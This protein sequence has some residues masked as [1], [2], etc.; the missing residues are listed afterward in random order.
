MN[1]WL[2]T[3]NPNPGIIKASDTKAKTVFL[4]DR[5]SPL[6]ITAIAVITTPMTT[7]L[8]TGSVINQLHLGILEL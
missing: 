6:N 2:Q 7:L 4:E 5:S 8:T 1:E 3:W